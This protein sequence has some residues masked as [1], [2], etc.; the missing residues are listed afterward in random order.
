M[1]VVDD[2][3]LSF[4]RVDRLELTCPK[5]AWL[6]MHLP[7][8]DRRPVQQAIKLKQN[9]ITSGLAIDDDH[10]IPVDSVRMKTFSLGVRDGMTF[11]IDATTE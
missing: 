2:T 5:V 11:V 3:E 10:V 4:L 6:R 1:R 9:T 8:R 7:T